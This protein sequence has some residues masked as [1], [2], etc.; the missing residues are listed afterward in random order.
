MLL[1][2]KLV[3]HHMRTTGILGKTLHFGLRV[4]AD[5]RCSSDWS[6]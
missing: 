1:G 6:G 5:H 2:P 3:M 4:T